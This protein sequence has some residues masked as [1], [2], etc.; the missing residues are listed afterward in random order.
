MITDDPS[1]AKAAERESLSVLQVEKNSV[2][3]TGYNTGFIGGAACFAPYAPIEEIL[4]CGDLNKHPNATEIV[5]F[6]KRNNK[7]PIS[8]SNEPLTDVGTIFLI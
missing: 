7:V 1:I 5:G 2:A 6:C 4:F 3:L 8:L